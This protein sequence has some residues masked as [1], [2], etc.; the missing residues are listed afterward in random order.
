MWAQALVLNESYSGLKSNSIVVRDA[1]LE[2]LGTIIKGLN[3]F[4]S[5]LSSTLDNK[6]IIQRMVECIMPML[7]VS[8][9]RAV[10]VGRFSLRVLCSVFLRFSCV[11]GA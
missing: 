4:E 1:V 5:Y 9:V 3:R 10:C 8:L 11:R 7:S 2:L 6:Q